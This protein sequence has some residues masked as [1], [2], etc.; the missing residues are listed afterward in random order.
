MLQQAT[1]LANENESSREKIHSAF[2]RVAY[3]AGITAMAMGFIVI[4]GWLLDLPTLQRF[5]YGFATMKMNTAVALVLAG[6]S[7]TL[8]TRQPATRSGILVAR[9]GALLVGLLGAAALAEYATGVE[10]G[11]DQLLIREPESL[12]GN[13]PGRMAPNTALCFVL[14][15]MALMLF[16]S[17]PRASRVVAQVSS[18]LVLFIGFLAVS[19]YLLSVNALY[20]VAGYTSMALPTAIG[21]TLL[22]AGLLASRPDRGIAEILAQANVAGAAIRRFLPLLVAIPLLLAWLKLQG[23]HAG[24]FGADFGAALTATLTVGLL[25]ALALRNARIHGV[26]ESERMHTADQFRLAMEG[27]PNGMLI[28]DARGRIVIVNAEVE[29]LFGYSRAELD[30]GSRRET[31]S[32]RIV[33]RA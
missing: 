26:W 20:G 18:L 32:S 1:S 9:V 22:S 33:P 6:F 17:G 29:R 15:S 7:L 10:L 16:D 12:D 28:V 31:D 21:F 13:P 4:A 25:C 3:V 2:A 14:L 19:G 30:R 24:L 5:G 11:I 27:S 23:T 8:T